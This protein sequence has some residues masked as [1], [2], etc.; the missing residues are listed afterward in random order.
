M[1]FLFVLKF[2]KTKK[3]V[4]KEQSN[5]TVKRNGTRT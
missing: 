1:I 2:Q 5:K 3:H 4:I